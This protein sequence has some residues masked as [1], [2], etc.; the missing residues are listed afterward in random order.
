MALSFIPA[1]GTF[2]RVFVRLLLAWRDTSDRSSVAP[3]CL[4]YWNSGPPSTLTPWNTKT[5]VSLCAH[6][7]FPLFLSP[8]C[9]GCRA[10]SP[11]KVKKSAFRENLR[12]G[13]AATALKPLFDVCLDGLLSRFLW[14]LPLPAFWHETPAFACFLPGK[15]TAWT[16]A[17]SVAGTFPAAQGDVQVFKQCLPVRGAQG[18]AAPPSLAEGR[19][20]ARHR[21][22]FARLVAML[23]CESRFA[24]W[25]RAAKRVLNLFWACVG[26]FFLC[27][28]AYGCPA[29]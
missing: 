1:L 21:G 9:D 2:T 24:I 15:V 23:H 22:A 12:G 4:E 13:R 26:S 16:A 8:R 7:A 27:C 5:Q 6:R 18:C 20:L 11:C 19:V 28:Y 10:I 17:S 25:K 29:M 3:C 14:L